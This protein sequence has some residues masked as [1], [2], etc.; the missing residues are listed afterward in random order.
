MQ[1][2]TQIEYARCI[3]CLKIFS[4]KSFSD[5]HLALI[6]SDGAVKE[7]ADNKQ[8]TTQDDSTILEKKKRSK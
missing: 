1:N 4:P 5:P 3:P 7:A 6:V 2:V 8:Q